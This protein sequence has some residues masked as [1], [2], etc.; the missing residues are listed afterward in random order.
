MFGRSAASRTG[1][2]DG[3]AGAMYGLSFIASRYARMVDTGLPYSCLRTPA[4]S[5]ACDTPR[6]RMK[7]P[8]LS[9]PSVSRAAFA[10]MG[11]RA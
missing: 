4:T 11:S 2:S 3:G 9:S 7:R 8:P 10:V 6:P 5:C 1:G